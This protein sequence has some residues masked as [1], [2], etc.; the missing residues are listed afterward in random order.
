MA[1]VAPPEP[2]LAAPSAPDIA[3]ILALDQFKLSPRQRAPSSG[4]DVWMRRLGIPLGIAAFGAVALAPRAADLTTAGQLSAA[5]FALALVWWI[6]EPVPTHVTSLVLMVLLVVSRAQEP[7]RVMSVLGLDV[8]WLNVLAFILSAMLVKTKLAKRLAMALILRVGRR[9]STALAG[10]VILQLILAPLIPATAARAAITLPLMIAVAA[11]YGSTAEHPTN[12]GRNL[13]LLNLAGISIL[14]STVMTGSAANVMAVGFLQTMAGHRVY[15]SDWLLAS[16]PI[17]ILTML[18]AWAMSP[19]LVFPLHAADRQPVIGGGM[20]MIRGELRAMGGMTAREWR[21]IAI[22]ALVIFLWATDRFQQRWFG[23]E[24]GPS[25]SAMIGAVIALSPKIGVL[26][27]DDTDIPWHL[28]I[29]S[30]GA[31]AGGLALENTGA[32]A[33]AVGRVFD[34]LA[35]EHVAFG[36]TYAVVLAVM[37]YSHLLSTS[38]TVRTVIMVPAIILLARGLGWDPAS[39]ALP[40]AFTIDWVIG[41]PISGKPNVILF[42]TNQYSV[43]DNLLFGLAVCTVGYLL[44]LLAGATYFHWIGL[45]PAFGAMH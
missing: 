9:A 39:L 3:E 4:V 21:A 15:Y 40:A 33:W 12:F 18:A 25:I 14:S 41:L 19:R 42:G 10:F 8:I 34:G 24:I 44:L 28:M 30:A 43:K 23:V 5:A 20:D 35:L 13:F 22:F 27:W 11:I 6:C 45:T 7:A 38:K 31:Y 29:F 16:A 32:A 17:A 1:T 36:W 37:L 26:N 2:R